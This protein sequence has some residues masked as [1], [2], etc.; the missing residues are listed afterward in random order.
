[1]KNYGQRIK[2]LSIK[3][4]VWQ[5]E[6]FCRRSQM[7]EWFFGNLCTNLL[8][9]IKFCRNFRPFGSNPEGC[10]ETFWRR[11]PKLQI[12]G[13]STSKNIYWNFNILQ[14]HYE[15]YFNYLGLGQR[16][17]NVDVSNQLNNCKWNNCLAPIFET[18]IFETSQ[19]FIYI[20]FTVIILDYSAMPQII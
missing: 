16:T 10:M 11:H 15:I 20:M 17:M 3:G 19:K 4:N 14:C 6:S 13:T 18:S 1:M 2:C 9:L 5:K 7:F 12:F 8:H